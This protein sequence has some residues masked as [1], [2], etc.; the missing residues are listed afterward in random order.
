VRLE[1]SA[2]DAEAVSA[3]DVDGL[4]IQPLALAEVRIFRHLWLGGGYGITLMPEVTAGTSR[5]DPNAAAACT[6]ANGDLG[7]PA[8]QAR[9]EGRA[10]PSAAGSYRRAVQDFGLT[11]TARF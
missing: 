1:T 6:A 4:K 7:D 2:L 9:L 3:G 11:I 8:C 5:F 10:R